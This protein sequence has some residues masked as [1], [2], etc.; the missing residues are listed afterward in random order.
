MDLD[1]RLPI[2]LL[3]STFGLLIGGYGLAS[4]PRIYAEH[5]LGINVN[6][7]W[8]VA[9]LLFGGVMLGYALR[10]RRRA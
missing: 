10:A 2:G 8:G 9:L 3:F 6:V 7:G 4:D 1:V 5:S